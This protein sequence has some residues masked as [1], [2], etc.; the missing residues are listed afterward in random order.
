MADKTV[1]FYSQQLAGRNDLVLY[2]IDME[3][4]TVGNTGGTSITPGSNGKFSCVI[5]ESITG[6]WLVVV[7]D[8]NN[9]PLLENGYV[10]FKLD[11]AGIYHVE[12]SLLLFEIA[13]K[14]AN[15][16]EDPVSADDLRSLQNNSPMELF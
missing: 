6:I 3:E 4:G 15:V 11:V 1:V 13:E 12:S 10:Y 9:V 14:T 8:T 16:P 5:D 2:L 7:K